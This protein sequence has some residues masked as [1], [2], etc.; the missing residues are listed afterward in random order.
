M[1]PVVSSRRRPLGFSREPEVKIF[2]S[3]EV[4]QC[5]ERAP[6]PEG[7]EH[8]GGWGG[9]DSGPTVEGGPLRVGGTDPLKLSQRRGPMT[10]DKI[11]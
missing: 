5:S 8:W 11:V 10:T 3:T 1:A 9:K 7:G 2:L 4:A 6:W